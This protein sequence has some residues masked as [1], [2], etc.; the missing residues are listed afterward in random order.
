MSA[1]TD[2]KAAR[3]V[4]FGHAIQEGYF[5]PKRVN[6]SELARLMNVHRSTIMRDL[7]NMQAVIDEAKRLQAMLRQTPVGETFRSQ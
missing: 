4:A 6:M 5:D 2:T 3:L 7:E 1:R